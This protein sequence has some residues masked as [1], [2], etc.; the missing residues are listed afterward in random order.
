[1][2]VNKIQNMPN[3][4]AQSTEAQDRQQPKRNNSKE[5]RQNRSSKDT[6]KPPSKGN[7]KITTD[8]DQEESSKR[9]DSV[10]DE[11]LMIL[12]SQLLDSETTINILAKN[13]SR[14][15]KNSTLL[16]KFLSDSTSE[17]PLLT[18]EKKLNKTA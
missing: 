8:S 16:K 14:P 5:K 4:V 17:K 2:D 3:A 10:S 6:L 11:N 9:Q 18:D 12:Q 13:I 15:V 1:M 7:I